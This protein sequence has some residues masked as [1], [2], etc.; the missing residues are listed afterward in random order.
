MTGITSNS[1][2]EFCC[3]D[4]EDAVSIPPSTFFFKEQNQVL[5]LTV[6][7][8]QTDQGPQWFDQAVLFCPFCGKQLQ[9]QEE[10]FTK[11]NA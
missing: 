10:I 7:Y 3:K 6:G 2:N 11:A 8:A 1:N 4:F 9:T 5:Y